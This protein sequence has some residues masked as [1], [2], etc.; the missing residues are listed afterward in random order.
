MSIIGLKLTVKHGAEVPIAFSG[1]PVLKMFWC[2]SVGDFQRWKQS[3]WHCTV[4]HCHCMKGKLT[5]EVTKRKTGK[6]GCRNGGKP[7]HPRAVRWTWWHV[8]NPAGKG[9]GST[10]RTSIS[11]WK[12]LCYSPLHLFHARLHCLGASFWQGCAFRVLGG[13][14]SN[15]RLLLPLR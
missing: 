7:P 11:V 12:S 8:K 14:M 6:L 13:S 5:H 15:T 2:E 10:A 1:G 9:V 4:W 3:T